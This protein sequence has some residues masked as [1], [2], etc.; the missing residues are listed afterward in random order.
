MGHAVD[1][2]YAAGILVQ[3]SAA[4]ISTEVRPTADRSRR[5]VP[6]TLWIRA[7]FRLVQSG[8]SRAET[9]FYPCRTIRA[10]HNRAVL[11]VLLHIRAAT[12]W[13]RVAG[14]LAAIEKD[15]LR[16]HMNRLT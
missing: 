13:A 11:S 5:D 16:E 14:P 3:F 1:R 2:T 12:L 10:N 9:I 15:I 7:G 4:T 6:G 8:F